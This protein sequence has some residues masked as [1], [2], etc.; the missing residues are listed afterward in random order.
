MQRTARA[1]R[2]IAPLAVVFLA[3]SLSGCHWFKKTDDAY[4][5]S[6]ESRPLEECAQYPFAYLQII[7]FMMLSGQSRHTAYAARL[8]AP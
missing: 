4:L 6:A 3:V 1:T 5:Q 8:F 2:T 7:F